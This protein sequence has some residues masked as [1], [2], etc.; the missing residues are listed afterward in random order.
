VG[1]VAGD[2]EHL[3]DEVR[4]CDLQSL[5]KDLKLLDTGK[6][7]LDMD[8]K[9]SDVRGALAL[10]LSEVRTLDMDMK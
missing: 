1:K 6:G 8:A 2:C 5:S 7:T 4:L 9:T 10:L 3:A